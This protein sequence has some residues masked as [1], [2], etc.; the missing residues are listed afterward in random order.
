MIQ[1]RKGEDILAL[2]ML[3]GNFRKGIKGLSVVSRNDRHFAVPFLLAICFTLANAAVLSERLWFSSAVNL[4]FPLKNGDYAILHGGSNPLSNPFHSL[5][6]KSMLSISCSLTG[7]AI[8]RS[9]WYHLICLITEFLAGV[10]IVLA[11]VG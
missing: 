11:R 9:G 3:D 10:F 5:G 6:A 7:S 1:V 2:A 4:V 8:V